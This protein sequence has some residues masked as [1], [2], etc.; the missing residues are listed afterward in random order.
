MTV[1]GVARVGIRTGDV[2]LLGD[3][4]PT[5]QHFRGPDGLVYELTGPR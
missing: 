5:W 2:E 4:G 3:G 1:S